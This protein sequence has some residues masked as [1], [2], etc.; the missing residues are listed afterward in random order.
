MVVR[1]GLVSVGIVPAAGKEDA[2]PVVQ[3]G[4]AVAVQAEREGGERTEGL[5][6][7]A[8]LVRRPEEGVKVCVKLIF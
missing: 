7:V 2:A 1:Y 5:A 4:H 6:A 3:D 8:R